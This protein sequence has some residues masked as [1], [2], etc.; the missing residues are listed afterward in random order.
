ME[1][2]VILAGVLFGFGIGILLMEIKSKVKKNDQ[3]G[4][5]INFE[6]QGD[7]GND[8]GGQLPERPPKKP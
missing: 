7:G 4:K 6:K 1:T 5:I 8:N 2:I 3:K